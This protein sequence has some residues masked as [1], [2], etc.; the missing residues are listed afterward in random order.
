MSFRSLLRSLGQ[1]SVDGPRTAYGE[2]RTQVGHILL[3]DVIGLP[4]ALLIGAWWGAAMWVPFWLT[5]EALQWR[6]GAGLKMIRDALK[7]G[8]FWS[9][10]SARAALVWLALDAV[11]QVDPALADEVERLLWIG[12]DLMMTGL[13]AA[14]FA[15]MLVGDRR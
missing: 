6:R 5:A 2:A 7:D 8:A 3:G 13:L 4:G 10:G 14:A 11:A 12:C 15:G 9:L 1:S